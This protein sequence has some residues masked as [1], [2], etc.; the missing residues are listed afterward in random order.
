VR[1]TGGAGGRD[2]SV[3]KKSDYGLALRLG[4]SLPNG[5]LLYG[6]GGPVR[7]RFNTNWAKGND[8]SSNIDRSYVVN[9]V[10]YGVGAEIPLG[11]FS[12]VRLDYTRTD[13]DS[14]GFRTLHS[15]PDEMD[16]DNKESL[17]RVGL[18]FRF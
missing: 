2:F 7:G 10:R 18:G 17:F 16:F 6:R 11:Q 8:V 13:Y 4:Y 5:T 14:Y 1:E 15:N 12:F 9:G 3:E